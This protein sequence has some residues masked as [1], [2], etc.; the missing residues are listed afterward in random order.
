MPSSA[1]VGHP[2]ARRPAHERARRCRRRRRVSRRTPRRSSP[3]DL[4]IDWSRPAV[5]IDRVVRVGSRVDDVP[6][7]PAAGARRPPD[8]RH[9][10]RAR[11]AARR[12]S[13]SARAPGGFALGAVQPEGRKA[14]GRTL[15][16]GTARASSPASASVRDR[17]SPTGLSRSMP[18]CTSSA[19]VPTRTSRFPRLL[20]RERPLGPRPRLRHRA[21]LRH[22]ADAARVRLA[23]RSIRLEAPRPAGAHCPASRRLPARLHGHA[24]ARGGRRDRPCRSG[25]RAGLRQRSPAEGRVST[26]RPSRRCDPTELSGLDRRA[27]HH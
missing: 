22:V 3:A 16:G 27:A 7:Q 9:A 20:S 17:R 21:R 23:G 15:R 24:A 2:P 26:V 8:R 1:P 11:H 25:V 10:G 18:S 19:T 12:A 6:G 5:E 4:E 14:V 13:M